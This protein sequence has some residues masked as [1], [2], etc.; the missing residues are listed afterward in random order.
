VTSKGLSNSESQRFEFCV[1]NFWTWHQTCLRDLLI[2]SAARRHFS[3]SLFGCWSC[4]FKSYLTLLLWRGP[5]KLPSPLRLW[6]ICLMPLV[7]FLGRRLWDRNSLQGRIS[8]ARIFR[9]LS[10]QFAQ[11]GVDQRLLHKEDVSYQWPILRALYQNCVDIGQ[12]R[13]QLDYS[14]NPNGLW[15]PWND[16]NSLGWRGGGSIRMHEVRKNGRQERCGLYTQWTT[17]SLPPRWPQPSSLGQAT[18]V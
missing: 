3:I 14:I 10:I 13:L 12:F 4:S 9:L 16:S 8:K 11:K 2:F 1:W 15:K 17:N 5:K 18:L 7:L 6:W